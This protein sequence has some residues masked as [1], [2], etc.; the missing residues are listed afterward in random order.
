MAKI[1]RIIESLD[2]QKGGPAYST[3]HSSI[4]LAKNGHEV[5]IITLDAS[6]KKHN[7]PNNIKI[8]NLGPGFFNYGLSLDLFL[9]LRK[10]CVQFDLVTVHGIWQW[11]SLS[12]RISKNNNTKFIV[13]PHGS[14]DVWDR[15]KRPFNFLFKK[16]YWNTIERPLYK[17]ATACLFTSSDEIKNSRMQ[18]NLNDINTSLTP[19]GTPDTNNFRTESSDDDLHHFGYMGR[20]HEKKGIEILIDSLSNLVKI[21]INAKLTITGSGEAI[22]IEKLQKKAAQ[23]G[24][25][26]HITWTG[27][28]H[29]KKKEEMLKSIGLFV[30]PSYQENFGLAVAEALSAG[31]PCLLSTAV[32]IHREVVSHDSG[33][34]IERNIESFSNQMRLWSMGFYKD[35]ILRK[36][37]RECYINNFSISSFTRKIESFL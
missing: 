28:L 25:S 11:P 29:G 26:N 19:Y 37:A 13:M 27:P 35:K 2:P 31:T 23:Q 32:N 18:F 10:N 17:K 22:Y 6:D 1:L 9:W 36:N 33:I 8:V 24:V 30:L 4:E 14:L 16:I 7:T 3:L 21:G 34:A 20:V 15:N 12:F 5:T